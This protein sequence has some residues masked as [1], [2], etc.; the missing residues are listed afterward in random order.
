VDKGYSVLLTI[1]SKGPL[2]NILIEKKVKYL[3]LGRLLGLLK[4]IILIIQNDID[5][6]HGNTIISLWSI[7]IAKIMRKKTVLHIREDISK[8]VIVAKIAGYFSDK[9]IIL[10]DE[11]RGYFNEKYHKKL[12]KVQNGIDLSVINKLSDNEKDKL[13]KE[14][15][16]KNDVLNI[17]LIG[18][19]E[20]RKG[21]DLLINAVTKLKNEIDLNVL[22]IGKPLFGNSKYSRKIKKQCLENNLPVSFI[23]EIDYVLNLIQVIDVLCVPSLW[24]G[25]PRVI[26]EA[27]ASSKPVIASRVGGI[28]DM[29]EDGKTGILFDSKDVTGLARAIKTISN[30]KSLL[31]AMGQHGNKKVVDLFSIEKHVK[32][33]VNVYTRL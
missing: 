30:N 16:I 17:A 31:K 21:Q 26:L 14:L 3:N 7:V 6:V 23:G 4:F 1:P 13:K 28:P 10:S 11:M 8:N 20:E 27:M 22:M 32:E 15:N 18:T 24:E 19:I 29:V 33:V 5:I 2:E 12:V 25:L 9:I